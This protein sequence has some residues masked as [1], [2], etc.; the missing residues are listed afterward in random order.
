[1]PVFLNLG[2]MDVLAVTQ[3][4]VLILAFYFQ[5]AFFVTLEEES[6]YYSY[7]VVRGDF[8]NF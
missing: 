2:G 7:E 3:K 1:M 6:D 8:R 4:F 5:A